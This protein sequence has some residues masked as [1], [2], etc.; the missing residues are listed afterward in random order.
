MSLITRSAFYFG[1]IVDENNNKIDFN[2]GAGA[3]VA[4]MASGNYSITDY[5]T[6]VKTALDASGTLTYTV[7]FSRITRIFTI[8]STASFDLL[9]ASG[10]FIGVGAFPLLGYT[11]ADKTGVST[12][13][14]QTGSGTEYITQRALSGYVAPDEWQ[15]PVSGVA[16]ESTS[17]LVETV[18]FGTN[19]MI[20]F[21]NKYV[22]SVAQNVNSVISNNLN[23]KAECVTWLQSIVKK[24]HFE[25]MD[26]IADR[27]IFHKV[28]VVS[29]SSNRDGLGYKLIE[30]KKCTGLFSTGK[31]V[32][33]V[34]A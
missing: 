13:N 28:Q 14:G 34:V 1:H 15:N 27:N 31:I 18:T 7:T 2:E 25:F 4:T 3:L 24:G 30:H 11:G 17:G 23:G 9:V 26:D 20:E 33:K 6:A 21:N 8:S 22:T 10:L 19:E 12:Y 5:A 16:N 29:I 32:L